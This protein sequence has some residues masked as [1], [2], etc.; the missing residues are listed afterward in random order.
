MKTDS[1]TVSVLFVVIISI[2]LWFSSTPSYVPY[3]STVFSNQARFEAFSTRKGV[4][5]STTSDNS[6]IDSPVSSYLLNPP[7]S[8][9][10]AVSGFEGVGVF[11][12]PDVAT[13]EKLDIYSQAKGSLNAEGYGYYNSMGPLILDGNMKNMLQTRGGNSTGSSSVVGGS[14]A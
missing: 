13:A 10:K 6:S 2:A 8:G 5:Y 7:S 3:S 11:N 14:P 1:I 9:A 12:T 4:E